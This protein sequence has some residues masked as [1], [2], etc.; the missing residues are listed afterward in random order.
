MLSVL[1]EKLAE[2]HGLAI[3]ATTVA[4]KVEERIGDAPLRAELARMRRDA[5]ETRA[6]CLRIEQSFGESVAEE[7]LAHANT[8]DERA[9]DLAGAWLKA[10]AGPVKA[11][12]FLAMGE[13]AEVVTWTAVAALA[14][15]GGAPLEEA[16]ALAEWAL[17]IQQRHLHVALEGTAL[18]SETADPAAPRWG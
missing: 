16:R 7:M 6:R 2:A 12:T 17:P 13:A 18:L 9:A 11:W 10:D 8:T 15:N 3:A 4:R 14:A 1:Q 5:E